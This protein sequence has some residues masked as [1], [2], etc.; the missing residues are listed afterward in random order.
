MEIKGIKVVPSWPKT[1]ASE[2]TNGR[3]NRWT[4]CPIESNPVDP[5]RL[6]AQQKKP[7]T[8]VKAPIH[9]HTDSDPT[10]TKENHPSPPITAPI[11]PDRRTNPD[12]RTSQN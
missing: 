11:H 8:P 6:I 2:Q 7:I 10:P 3:T 1:V 5:Q 9:L 12:A 4:P